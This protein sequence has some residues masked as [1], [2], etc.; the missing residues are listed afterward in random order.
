MCADTVD[1]LK[2]FSVLLYG[3]NSAELKHID[4]LK[5]VGYVM[6]HK[7]YH[8]AFL[9]SLNRVHSCVFRRVR[10]SAKSDY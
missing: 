3:N 1:V 10:K 5:P 6:Y 8:S 2:E 9:R 7:G 4:N